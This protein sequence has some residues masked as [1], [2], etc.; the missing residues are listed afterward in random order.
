[1]SGHRSSRE[2]C[3]DRAAGVAA[4]GRAGT[5]GRPAP[6]Q[7][8]APCQAAARG[9]AQRRRSARRGGHAGPDRVDDLDGVQATAGDL[10]ADAAPAAGPPDHGQLPQRVQRQHRRHLV[11]D[12]LHQQHAGDIDRGDPVLAGRPARG[13][14]GGQVPVPVPHLAADHAARGADA[15]AAGAG[16]RAV[17]RLQGAEPARQPAGAD[18]ALYGVRAADLHL[19][20]AQ[21]RGR[22]AAGDGGGSGDRR[23][24]PGPD[25]LAD[26]LPPGGARPGGDQR[27]RVH[28]RLERVRV[29]AHLPEP[30]HPGEVHPADLRD[31]LHG[32]AQLRLGSDHGRLH[33]LHDP[34]HPV[35]PAG[36]APDGPRPGR[37]GG[38]GMS[39]AYGAGSLTRLADAVLVPPFPGR[40][41]PRWLLQAL[42]NGLAGVTLFGPNVA[43]PEQLSAL[44]AA[45]RAVVPELVI[46]ID[47]E[48]G[49]VTR[50]AHLTGSPYP[51]NAALGAVDD[52]A[53]TRA[54]YQALGTDLAAVGINVDLAPSV[55]V[56]TAAGNPIIGTRSFGDRTGLV[57]RHA[58]AAVHGLQAAGVGACAKHFPG[59]GSTRDDTHHV[60]ATV[61]GDL[62]LVRERDLP[63][64]TAAIAA[65]VAAI[66]PGHL[67]IPGVTGDLPATQSAAAL[68]GLLR[69]E[70]GF[71]GVIILDA[72]EMRAVSAR[73]GI[74]DA[75]VRAVAAGVDLLCLGRDQDEEAYLAV[76]TAI[77]AAVWAGTL[78]EARLEEAAARVAGFRAML[79]ERALP[80]APGGG[81]RAGTGLPPEPGNGDG[82]GLTAA[83][84][85]LRVTGTPG[86]VTDPV[87]IE[88]APPGNIAVGIVPWGLEPWLPAGSV[89][90]VPA[91]GAQ[92]EQR[93][94]QALRQAAGRTVIAVIRDA[95]RDPGAQAVITRLLAARPDTIVLEMGLPVWRPAARTYLATYGASRTSGQA[96]AELL[97]LTPIAG[98]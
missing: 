86:T 95:H 10:L 90:R 9:G 92:A 37:R 6:G 33:P 89:V 28:L 35:L 42:E 7:H 83:R 81:P 30:G 56:N 55:D 50:L 74:T 77:T 53:L 44:T 65:G 31:V 5:P 61:D 93:L 38:E 22:R 49:D 16:H 88:V 2:H 79:A 29:R 78:T 63:P 80:G 57:S 3:G 94:S 84:R 51:G 54:V 96:A 19:D 8:R 59:H 43:G 75:A 52:V 66:M 48:G 91:D 40:S 67:R 98:H 60:V 1:M 58:A 39:T 76:R 69:G 15:A 64:F 46:A 97:G 4:V 18:P 26:P 82:I 71:T 41:A 45:L 62:A 20:A 32:P 27:V 23:R 34:A 25:L 14:R 12:V 70:L 17:H 85:A 11:L 73:N 68:G 36:A 87:V 24:G 21:L 47:E 13:G 72:L